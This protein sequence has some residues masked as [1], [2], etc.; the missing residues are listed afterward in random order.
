MKWE[1]KF[2]APCIIG[3]KYMVAVIK[4]DALGSLI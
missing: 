2:Q 4:I 1:N 3:A